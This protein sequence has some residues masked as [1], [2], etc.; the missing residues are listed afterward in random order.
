MPG[1]GHDLN[2]AEVAAV[3]TYV[4]NSWGHAA[5]AVTAGEVSSARRAA[6]PHH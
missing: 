6:R 5:S 2:D 4:R 1:F 3:A